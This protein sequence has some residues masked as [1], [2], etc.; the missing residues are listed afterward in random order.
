M[1]TLDSFNPTT[2]PLVSS[3]SI[4]VYPDATTID[5]VSANAL[6][7][8]RM[9]NADETPPMFIFDAGD[10]LEKLDRW[11]RL[12]PSVEPFYAVKCNGEPALLRLLADFGVHFDCASRAEIESVLQVIDDEH[13]GDRIVFANPCKVASHVR[14]AAGAGVRLVTFDSVGELVKMK[15]LH[16]DAR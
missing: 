15:K 16:P 3:T 2:M 1:P 8:Q 10:V 12:L 7:S 4:N 14:Y 9:Q 6:A 11:R 5:E 13:G